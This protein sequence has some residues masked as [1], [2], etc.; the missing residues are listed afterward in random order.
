MNL[1]QGVPPPGVLGSGV[2]APLGALASVIYGKVIAAR[3]VAFDAGR[4]VVHMDRPVISVG[5]LSVGGTGKTPMVVHVLGVL[6]DAGR[7]PC[8]AMRGYRAGPDGSDEAALYRR[9][10]AG[11]PIVARP[12]RVEGLIELFATSEGD[13]VDTI[14]LDDGF[15]HRRLA[16]QL[17]IV[18]LDATRSVFLD[19]LLP[20]GWLREPVSS[21]ARAHAVVVT[22]AE[23]V[24]PRIVD[25][26]QRRVRDVAPNILLTSARHEWLDLRVHHGHDVQVRPVDWLRSKRVV[27]ACA[28]GNPDA[29]I[30][31][32]RDAA[33]REL[34]ARVVLRDHDP[35]NVATIARIVKAAEKCD[36]IVVT[37]KDWT[38][39]ASVPSEKWPCA[40][41]VPRLG[42]Q[43]D[44]GG[45]ELA[46][47]IIEASRP[48]TRDEPSNVRES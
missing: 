38:K 29:F 11:V 8:V 15:Q 44:R 9:V 14:V 28:I 36:A 32:V 31:H 17:D 40:V 16:R 26:M 27:A 48:L 46:T 37:E 21:L 34:V 33:G 39:L 5:N 45:D 6:R 12:D 22:H 2:L 13:G 20:S 18:L 24:P 19:Q 35:F 25:D 10:R 47:M 7:K 4:G 42:L 1:S 3:N 43:F 30:A 23:R 41:A